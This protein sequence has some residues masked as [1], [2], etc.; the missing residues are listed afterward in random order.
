MNSIV[1]AITGASAMQIGERSIQLLLEN[2]KTVAGALLERR[3]D[4]VTL[5]REPKYLKG[6]KVTYTIDMED[7][8]FTIEINKRLGVKSIK[9]TVIHEMVHVKQYAE[10]RLTQTEWMGRPHPDL[11]YRELPWEVEAWN[12]EKTLG[13]FV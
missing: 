2:N 11:P 9:K 12:M 10:G 8:E 1:I 5:Y 6:D 3:H 7:G 13:G 4:E